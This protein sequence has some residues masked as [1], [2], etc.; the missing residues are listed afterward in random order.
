MILL[1]SL[2]AKLKRFKR[3]FNILFYFILFIL[4]SSRAHEHKLSVSSSFSPLQF[5]PSGNAVIT[6]SDDCTCKMYD[7][8]SDQEV[9]GYQDPNLNA[10]V[11]SLALS[12]SGRLIFAGYDDFNCHIWDSLKGEKVGEWADL[13]STSSLLPFFSPLLSFSCPVIFFSSSSSSSSRCAVRP[14]QQGELH[15]RPRRRHGRLHRI[16]GQL[17]QTVEL[18]R[19]SREKH[20]KKEK[21]RRRRRRRRGRGEIGRRKG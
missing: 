7:L 12:N 13:V 21:K 18:R 16:L 3:K 10:G 1:D 15:R 2:E 8:R 11:T 6:G 17:P 5:F 20:Q 9:I 19:L 14:R 4:T